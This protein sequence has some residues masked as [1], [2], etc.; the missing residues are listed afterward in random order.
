MT[1]KNKRTTLHLKGLDCADCA[2]KLADR[3]REIP[4]VQHA[5][6]DFAASRLVLEAAAS[7]EPVLQTIRD[8]GYDLENDGRAQA[9]TGT[10]PPTRLNRRVVSTVISG[11]ALAVGLLLLFFTAHDQAATLAFIIAILSG[12]VMMARGAWRALRTLSL[13]MN[14]LMI[15]AVAGA[16]L[17]GE[18]AE[19]AT[20]VF[21][22]AVSNALQAHTMDRTRRSIHGLMELSPREAL[23]RRAGHLRRLPVEEIRVGDTMVIKP[24]ERIAMDGV[25]SAG[26]S[27]VNQAA[28]T[29]ES[30]P[31]GKNPGDKVFAGTLNQEGMLEVRVTKLVANSTLARIIEMVEEAEARKSP[32]QQFV[33]VFARYY[34]PAVIAAAVLITVL[35]PVVLGAGFANWFYRALVLLVIACPCALVISTPVAIVTA[36]GHAARR[37]VLVKGGAQLELLARVRAVALDK[38]GTL[39]TGRPAVTDVV[40]TGRLSATQVLEAAAAVEAPSQHPLAT[41]IRR[42]AAAQGLR[43]PAA[44][45]FTSFTG[46]GAEAVVNGRVY[47]IG[48]PGFFRRLGQ[49]P[50]SATAAQADRLQREGKTVVL[51]GSETGIEGLIA[52]ADRLRPESEAAM[53]GLRREGIGELVLLTGDNPVTARAVAEKLGLSRFEAELLP[54]HKLK[55]IGQ[56]RH[57]RGPVAMVGEGINDAPAL[58]AADVGIAMGVAGTDTALETADVALM[59]DDLSR[60]PFII[61]LGRRTLGIIKQNVVFALAVKALFILLTVAGLATLWMAVFADTGAALIVILNS[62]R[63]AGRH[64]PRRRRDQAAPGC[65]RPD[66]ADSLSLAR[67]Y[68]YN[69]RQSYKVMEEEFGGTYRN[70]DG[71]CGHLSTLQGPCR[72]QQGQ[73]HHCPDTNP[74]RPGCAL[75]YDR[76][77]SID[78]GWQGQL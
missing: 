23:I 66:P 55:A 49:Q 34:T 63:L 37:G 47:R 15:I 41:A 13:D 45:D 9:L 33:D 67:D 6:I 51:L 5:K 38:T 21:L 30:M 58:A 28:I 48:S 35:P 43:P 32:A 78:N 60:L 7:L 8:A 73:T 39:T 69:G 25:V 22:F 40:T 17:I 77:Q 29:G 72:K 71:P 64:A 3:I 74:G 24:G 75:F 27:A 31:L 50:G 70:P 19:G 54:E 42:H 53:E 18:W 52:I 61:R 76:R 56:M 62:M 20:V 57:E 1:L 65:P 10:P 16:G 14:V 68:L 12:I 36:I 11:L 4:G 26:R 44:R 59:H 46:E 2:A